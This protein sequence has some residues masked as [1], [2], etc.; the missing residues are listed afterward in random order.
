M[1]IHE[2]PYGILISLV[3]SAGEW[4]CAYCE[5]KLSC[6][7]T[8]STSR[9]TVASPQDSHEDHGK[10]HSL[11][12]TI[13]ENQ[14]VRSSG[15]LTRASSF[16]DDVESERPV[17]ESASLSGECSQRRDLGLD[18]AS[19]ERQKRKREG[20]ED[21]DERKKKIKTKQ[22]NTSVGEQ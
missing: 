4:L 17:R 12:S 8:S 14:S 7:T 15:K 22:G 5:L 18:E 2:L 6:K 10:K 9:T 13:S 11:C 1:H 16:P 20:S 3:F 19:K 21:V